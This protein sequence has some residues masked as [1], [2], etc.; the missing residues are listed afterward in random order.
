MEAPVLS[1]LESGKGSSSTRQ[2]KEKPRRRERYPDGSGKQLGEEEANRKL[3]LKIATQTVA[4]MNEGDE[5][6]WKNSG[7]E[8][9]PSSRVSPAIT[10]LAKGVILLVMGLHRAYSDVVRTITQRKAGCRSENDL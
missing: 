7:R 9:S 10:T 5:R 6:K 4:K 3:T 2:R 1:T 8:A